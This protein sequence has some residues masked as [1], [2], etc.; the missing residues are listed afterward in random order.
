MPT[1]PLTLPTVPA[2]NR[3][4]FRLKRMVGYSES[5]SSGQQQTY[6]HP[7]ALWEC[8]VSLPPMRRDKAGPWT[9]FL[10]ECHGR[11]GTFLLGDWDGRVPRGTA[12]N[13][14]VNGAGQTGN[15][16]T[17]KGMGSGTTLLP[18]DW[19]QLGSGGDSRLHMITGGG[20]SANSGGVA[21]FQIEPRLKASPP[22]S[23]TVT[24]VNAKGVFRMA[25][26]DLGWDSNAVSIYGFTFAAVEAF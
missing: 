10:M 21:V 13:A 6:E 24:L 4:A 19:I 7:Y 25:S 23:A 18:G 17:L 9:S 8:E 16:I 12:R 5:F 20:N 26:N 3:T 1:Y 2:P 22:D 11:A 14:Q 15:Q